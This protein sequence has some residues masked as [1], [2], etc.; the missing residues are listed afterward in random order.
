MLKKVET[1][2]RRDK[3]KQDKLEGTLKKQRMIEIHRL[4][5]LLDDRKDRV[6][7]EINRKRAIFEELVLQ[8]HRA[9]F[10]PQEPI[11]EMLEKDSF[12][13]EVI[14]SNCICFIPFCTYLKE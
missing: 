2:V 4:R 7:K 6:R 12:N 10:P 5:N 13:D 9:L 8:E 1:V 3:K 14:F 11:E